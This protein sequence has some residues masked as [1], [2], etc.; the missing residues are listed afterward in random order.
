V[1]VDTARLTAFDLGL[2]YYLTSSDGAVTKP[3]KALRKSEKK[4]RREQRRLTRKKKGSKNRCKQRIRLTRV[5]EHVANQRRDFLHKTSRRVV[6]SHEGFAFEKLLI[7]NMLK[8]HSLAKAIADAGWSTF[9]SM[10]AYKAVRPVSRSCWLIL[11]TLLRFAPDVGLLCQ[12]SPPYEYTS[13]L[14]A[15]LY[16]TGTSRSD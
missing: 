13:A 5:H 2:N 6:D 4:L 12:R 3:L 14:S 9:L 10:V 15:L 8:N 16:S 11:V 7:K 1:P